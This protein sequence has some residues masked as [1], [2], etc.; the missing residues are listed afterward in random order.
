MRAGGSLQLPVHHTLIH[1]LIINADTEDKNGNPLYI[2]GKY[3]NMTK[4]T[5][6]RYSGMDAY[7]STDLGLKSREVVVY[8][9]SKTSSDFSD[10]GDLGSVIFM[11]NGDMLTILH[12]GMP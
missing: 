9:Y 2:M 5:L 1:H 4:L 11:G 12:S 6:G 8:N 10:H 7:T 3:R